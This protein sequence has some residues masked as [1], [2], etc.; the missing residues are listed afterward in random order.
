M[1]G[2]HADEATMRRWI[3]QSDSLTEGASVEQHLLSCS[4]C[5]ARVAALVRAGSAAS[6][7]DLTAV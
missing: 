7:V 5:R 3:D 6:P 2:W 4:P 1:T